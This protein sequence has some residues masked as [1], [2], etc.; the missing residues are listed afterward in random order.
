MRIRKL[1][2]LPSVI[3]TAFSTEEIAHLITNAGLGSLD[4]LPAVSAVH[5]DTT[6]SP[7]IQLDGGTFVGTSDGTTSK[8]YGIPFA[9]AP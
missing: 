6:A 1:F 9:K 5:Q 2:L 7:M 3:V 4:G 8:F